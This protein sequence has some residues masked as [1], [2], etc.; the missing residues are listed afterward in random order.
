MGSEEVGMQLETI[1]RYR[2]LAEAR[3]AGDTRGQLVHLGMKNWRLDTK[4]VH[5]LRQPFDGSSPTYFDENLTGMVV[6]I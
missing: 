5:L 1:P 6:D 3:N 4:R 2:A